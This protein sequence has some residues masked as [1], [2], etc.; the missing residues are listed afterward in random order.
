[1]CEENE[2]WDVIHSYTR[3][4]AIAD[5]VLVDV[6]DL[7]RKTGFKFPVAITEAVWTVIEAIPEV[8]KWT[9]NPRDRLFDVLTMAAYAARFKTN[10]NL[11]S[12]K[13]DMDTIQG[14]RIVDLKM[15]CG[16][17]DHVEPVATIMFPEED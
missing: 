16:P 10:L 13:V 7:A 6:S 8:Y 4:Q 11:V 12:F 17:V 3:A 1:M 2:D 15:I 5:G 14:R 9:Q